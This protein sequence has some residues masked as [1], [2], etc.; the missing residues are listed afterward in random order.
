M[1]QCPGQEVARHL[2]GWVDVTLQAGPGLC[3]QHPVGDSQANA[4]E[5]LPSG[6]HWNEVQHAADEPVL[7]GWLVFGS[8]AWPNDQ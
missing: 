1:M 5:V 2:G 8:K 3:Y 4:P 7:H 6:Q